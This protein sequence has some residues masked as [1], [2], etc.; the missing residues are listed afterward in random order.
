VPKD[1][2]VVRH[3]LENLPDGQTDWERV[4]QLADD[5]IEAAIRDDRTPR[6][7]ATSNGSNGRS[8]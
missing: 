6:R 4:D 2:P 7:S 1:E 8:S 3:S 5:E